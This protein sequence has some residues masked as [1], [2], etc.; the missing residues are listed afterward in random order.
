MLQ[1]EAYK[2]KPKSFAYISADD[3]ELS[4][5]L[6]LD[7]RTVQKYNKELENLGIMSKVNYGFDEAG[8]SKQQ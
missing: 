7:L 6:N 3:K 5:S 1:S 8:F 4:K 2:D